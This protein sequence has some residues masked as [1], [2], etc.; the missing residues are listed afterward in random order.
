[1][2][3]S[4]SGFCGS[5]ALFDARTGTFQHGNLIVDLNTLSAILMHLAND[6]RR[7]LIMRNLPYFYVTM[8]NR[9]HGSGAPSPNT[10]SC[11]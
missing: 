8:N 4:G 5:T 11:A 1:M 2:K 3:T 6:M 10:G 9:L 7:Q